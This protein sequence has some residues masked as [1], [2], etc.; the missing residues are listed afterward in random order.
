MEKLQQ[1]RLKKAKE[2]EGPDYDADI[3][4]VE[5]EGLAEE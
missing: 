3:G 5:I 4:G 1:A 2:E